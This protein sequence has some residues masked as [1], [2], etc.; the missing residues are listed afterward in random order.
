[1]FYQDLDGEF[2]VADDTDVVGRGLREFGMF[3]SF[4]QTQTNTG[5]ERV[6]QSMRNIIQT[7]L[8]S[9]FF[10]PSFGSRVSELV[11]EPNDFILRDL[12][13]LYIKEAIKNWEPRVVVE[14]VLVDTES[15]EEV[16]SVMINYRLK[17]RGDINNFVYSLNRDIAKL[18]G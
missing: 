3:D 16:C 12:I 2:V 1:M 18:G 6:V 9:R 17:D 10:L 11:F 14:E 4:G 5:Q 7:P 8:G 15:S 13:A